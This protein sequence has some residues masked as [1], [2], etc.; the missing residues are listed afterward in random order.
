MPIRPAR[1]ARSGAVVQDR[2]EEATM[3]FHVTQQ[4]RD[5]LDRDGG[6]VLRGLLPHALIQ[7]LRRAA[8]HASAIGRSA[9]GE[10]A[11]RLQPI[12]DFQEIDQRPFRD[13]AELPELQQAISELLSPRHRH[14][15]ERLG[16]LIEPTEPFSTAWH[17]DAFTFLGDEA[18]Y[19]DAQDHDLFWQCNCALWP[20]RALWVVP[21]SHGRRNTAAEQA[22][23]A[24][25]P[26]GHH[27]GGWDELTAYAA[28][29]PG[30]VA[31]ELEPGDYALY[32]A[33]QWHTGIYSPSIRRATLHDHVDTEASRAW[34]GRLRELARSR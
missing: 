19:R 33:C 18:F 3:P 28:G 20:D 30:A 12:S 32:R 1:V 4:H 22:H 27:A 7:D 2:A 10:L 17:R 23:A 6:T 16:L 14:G 11:Q 24:K 34:R 31:V 25:R 26:S 21:G 15:S 9:H 13:F 5:E 29:M 8:E